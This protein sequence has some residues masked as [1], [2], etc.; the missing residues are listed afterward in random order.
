MASDFFAQIDAIAADVGDGVYEGRVS[1]NQVYAAP[2]ERGFWE[3][4][5]LAGHVNHPR[6]GGQTHFL[7]DGL[8]ENRDHYLSQLA[9]QALEPDGIYKA[10]VDNVEHLSAQVAIRAP[11]EFGDLRRSGHPS[12]SHN[13][14]VVYDRP[15]AV[16]RLSR[17]EL[18][19]K[20]DL[21]ERAHKSRGRLTGSPW[22][23]HHNDGD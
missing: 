18:E 14:M 8:I 11:V 22:A 19:A 21:L 13:N 17:A 2:L 15:P 16:E 6:H 9:S 3:T 1:V 10:M 4:G 5:P 20:S 23:T 7:R 12:V